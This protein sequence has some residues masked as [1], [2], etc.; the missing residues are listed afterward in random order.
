MF[1]IFCYFLDN[2]VSLYMQTKWYFWKKQNNLRPLMISRKL[3]SISQA[4]KKRAMLNFFYNK[5]YIYIKKKKKRKQKDIQ[6]VIGLNFELH[7]QARSPTSMELQSFRLPYFAGR[8]FLLSQFFILNDNLVA[9]Q[10]KEV[11]LHEN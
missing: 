1:S 3:C 4:H 7:K 10:W 2:E 9:I 5:L 8:P 6:I 11:S